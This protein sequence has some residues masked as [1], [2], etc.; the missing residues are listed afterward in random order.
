MKKK[1]DLKPT[2]EYLTS[3]YKFL[4]QVAKCTETTS[5][6]ELENLLDIA[7][8]CIKDA[9]GNIMVKVQRAIRE[10]SNANVPPMATKM[11][12]ETR[13]DGKKETTEL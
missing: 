2:E 8:S 7:G 10:D 3:L 11:L 9:P 1:W 13:L 6:P 5:Y 4:E 12:A